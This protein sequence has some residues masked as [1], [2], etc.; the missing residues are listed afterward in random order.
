[1]INRY[2]NEQYRQEVLYQAQDF[3]ICGS[4]HTWA[5]KCMQCLKGKQGIDQK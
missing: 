3:K 4:W 2:W 5:S 1:M